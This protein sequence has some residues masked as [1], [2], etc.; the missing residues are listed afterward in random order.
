MSACYI[1]GYAIVSED[2]MLADARRVMPDTLIFEADQRFFEQGL[3]RID[4]VVHGRHSQERQARSHLRL[5]IIVTRRVSGIA[6][7]PSNKKALLWNPLGASLE[8]ALD[9]IGKPDAS[10]G[11][12][13]GPDTF[14]L[15]LDTFDVFYLTRAPAVYLPGGRPVFPEVPAR[16]PEDVL[17]S[18]GM[19]ADAPTMLDAAKGLAVVGW[20]RR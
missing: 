4:V 8:Q 12:I 15:F 18:H 19:I 2:G 20:R 13:G 10:I 5:R 14:A 17:S 1:E 6:P 16:S 11:V 3:D 9:A 7:H